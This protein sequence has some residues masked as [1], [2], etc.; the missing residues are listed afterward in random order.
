[1]WLEGLASTVT[2]KHLHE[3]FSFYG[4]VTKCVVNTMKKQALVYFDKIDSA[5]LAVQKM[6]GRTVAG[7]KIQVRHG[8]T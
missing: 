5:Q 8:V 4:T 7:K 6:T 2:E 3:M 1:M